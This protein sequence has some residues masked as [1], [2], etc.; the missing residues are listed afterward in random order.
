VCSYILK[1]AVPVDDVES[2]FQTIS[3]WVTKSR[4][5]R[6]GRSYRGDTLAT[7]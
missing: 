2:A 7:S 3:C 6:V 4:V 5:G 1:G